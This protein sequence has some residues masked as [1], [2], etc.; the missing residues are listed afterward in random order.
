M[1]ISILAGGSFVGRAL[2]GRIAD[3]ECCNRLRILQ[4][5]LILIAISTTLVAFAPSFV[6]V[7]MYAALFGVCEGIY[8]M[9]FMVITRDVVGT[10]YLS[11]ALGVAYCIMSI[12]KTLGPLL[13][14][15]LFDMAQSYV[16]PFSLM[17]A[18]TTCSTLLIFFVGIKTTP[19]F[20]S[21][22]GKNND[23]EVSCGLE[24]REQL[25]MMSTCK[26]TTV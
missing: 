14:G 22:L 2:C 20:L 3:L 1:L 13:A 18:L 6:L 5:S 19:K 25:S 17:G 7:A 26:E 11:F 21:C 8:V 24:K 23:E 15:L 12:P 9:V 4:I 10:K 16:L